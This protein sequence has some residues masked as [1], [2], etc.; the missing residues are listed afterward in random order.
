MNDKPDSVYISEYRKNITSDVHNTVLVQK[1]LLILS[2][3]S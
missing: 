2:S 3:E 1:L